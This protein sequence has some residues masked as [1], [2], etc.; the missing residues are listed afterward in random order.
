MAS[1]RAASL[2]ILPL[3]EALREGRNKGTAVAANR[4]AAGGETNTASEREEA[5]PAENLKEESGVLHPLYDDEGISPGQ[6]G[7]DGRAGPSAAPV[8]TASWTSALQEGSQFTV[9]LSV[10]EAKLLPGTGRSGERESGSMECVVWE[11]PGRVSG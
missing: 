5:A 9:P 10:D 11:S 3:I 7:S 6:D 8:V 2:P 1:R 4:G